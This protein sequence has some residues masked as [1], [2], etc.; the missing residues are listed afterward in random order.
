[1][2]IRPATNADSESLIEL[3]DG[4]YRE[5]GDVIFLEGADG[6]LLDLEGQYGGKGGA[7]VVLE[8]GGE[9]I[10]AHAV[11]PLDRDRG[12]VT[13]RRLYLRK[14]HRGKGHGRVL[15]QWAIDWARREGYRKVEFWSDLRFEGAH[16]FFESLG[17]RRGGIREMSDGAMPYS[18]YFFARNL[19]EST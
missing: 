5:Y 6:D 18:E 12:A 11:L 16:G 3:V 10:G 14:D 1:M 9:V 15:M 13:F 8:E 19:E 7:F 2:K 4:V 17:F